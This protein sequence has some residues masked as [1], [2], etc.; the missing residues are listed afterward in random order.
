M[1]N[2]TEDLKKGKEMEL[3]VMSLLNNNW[4]NLIQNPVEKEMDLLIIEKWIEV[5]FDEYAQYSWNFYIE[6]ECNWKPS[7]LLREEKVELE[8]WAHSDWDKVYLTKWDEL[9]QWVLD[10]VQRCR[11]N[12][13]LKHKQF[14]VV[15][16]W[17]NGWRTK[18]LLVPVSELE[19]QSK[20]V[21]QL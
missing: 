4:F 12:K 13:T 9:K 3:K 20:Y 17:G 19:N 21:Y 6:F 14:R 10:L 5:K 15:E 2:F 7:G 1:W 18:W 16:N 11:A 8:Y